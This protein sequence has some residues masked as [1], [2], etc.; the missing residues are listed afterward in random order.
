MGEH[1]KQRTLRENVLE[2]S[3]Q[4]GTA[5][6]GK[7]FPLLLLEVGRIQND[8]EDKVGMLLGWGSLCH[9]TTTITLKLIHPP[10]FPFLLTAKPQYAARQLGYQP[11][12]HFMK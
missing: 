7:I 10:L 11:L 4:R 5:F 6:Y 3:K 2:T 8:T 1:R 12:V 9:P